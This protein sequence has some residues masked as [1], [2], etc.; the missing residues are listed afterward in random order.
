MKLTSD[1]FTTPCGPFSAALTEDGAIVATA[2]GR[3]DALQARLPVGAELNGSRPSPALRAAVAAYFKNRTGK[4]NL[5]LRL[6]G[7]PFQ[8][9]VWAA[10][11]QIPVGQ[12]RSYG[13]I[14]RQIGSAPRAVGR[15]N[16][17]NPICLFI[18]CHRVI[19]ANAALTGYAFGEAIKQLLLEHEGALRPARA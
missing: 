8:Q 6:I 13:D 2:F 12:T 1:T 10:L 16:A 11:R 7:S 17:T 14:A 19:G 4:L 5:S 18:P 3:T 15:A 9:K